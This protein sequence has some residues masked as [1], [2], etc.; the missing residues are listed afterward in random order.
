MRQISH[1]CGLMKYIITIL[2]I[3]LLGIGYVFI[4]KPKDEPIGADLTIT[5][6]S[7]ALI[8]KTP[9]ERASIKSKAIEKLNMAG[10]YTKENYEI[11]IIGE[12]KH[13]EINGQHGIELFAKAWKDGKQIGFGKDGSVEI[14]R[15]RIY[16]PP[17]MNEDPTGTIDQVFVNERTGIKTIKKLKEDLSATTKEYLTGIIKAVGKENTTIV[18]GKIGNTTSTFNPQTG[19]GG[20]NVS[21]DGRL[22]ARESVAWAA[23]R[24]D[25]TG[26]YDYGSTETA[27]RILID[28]ITASDFRLY[29]AFVS[30][31]TSALG[32]DT[33]SSATFVVRSANENTFSTAQ[34]IVHTSLATPATLATTDWIS[35]DGMIN[36]MTLNSNAVTPTA[37]VGT[38]TTFTLNAAGLA[39]I[40]KTGTSQFAIVDNNSDA[41]DVQYSGAEKSIYYVSADAGGA[42]IPRL[43]VVH[44]AAAAEPQSIQ[45]N[46]TWF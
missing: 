31:G 13:I 3:V 12:I 27:F 26:V 29:R 34:V 9:T 20:A 19:E 45:V 42:Y 43:I 1:N 18:K 23:T 33:I 36:A 38:D 24:E 16:N 14:E 40:N 21:Q 10:K 17:I 28:D 6:V 44:E 41:L 5:P 37:G 30:F 8:G 7:D 35:I 4:D 2:A 32:T 15:F 39:N 11:E 22:Q 46:I 25:V